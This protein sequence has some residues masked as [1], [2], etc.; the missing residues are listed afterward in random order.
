MPGRG[1]QTPELSLAEV[2]SCGPGGR[3]SKQREQQVQR[4]SAE[5]CVMSVGTGVGGSE[6]A[7]EVRD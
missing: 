3:A 2:G 7:G 5:G 6:A 1:G 4:L